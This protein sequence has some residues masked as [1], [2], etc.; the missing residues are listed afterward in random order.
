MPLIIVSVLLALSLV[1]NFLTCIRRDR[2]IHRI[3]EFIEALRKGIKEESFKI[4]V[5]FVELKESLLSNFDKVSR[6]ISLQEQSIGNSERAGMRLSRNIEKAVNSASQISI[7]TEANRKSA[8]DLFDSVTEGSAAVEE[9]QAALGSFRKQNDRQNQSI[10]ETADAISSMNQSIKGVSGIAA[11]RLDSVKTLIRVTS[12]SSEK[13]QENEDVIR[14][15]QKQVDDVLSLITVINDIASQT[16]L[17]SMNAAI[18]AAHAGE[19][20]KGFAV[21]AEEIR[22]L[23]EST[24]QNSHIISGTL[25]K[26]VEHINR[27]GMIS[28][29]SGKSFEQIEKGAETV[30]EAFTVIHRDT[31][32]LL[33]SAHKLSLNT[34][35]LQEIAAEST[36]SISEIEYGTTDI[37]KVLQDSKQ[38]A[39][40]LTEDMQK[41]SSESK[42]SNFNLTKVSDSYLKTSESFLDI[43]QAS[44]EYHGKQNQLENKLF[45]SNLMVAHVNWMGLSRAILDGSFDKNVESVMDE[46]HSR[47]GIWINSR[48]KEH[49]KDNK[50]FEKL[51]SRHTY[52]HEVLAEIVA[53]RNQNNM[54][55]AEKKFQELTEVSNEIVQILMTLGYSDFV[56]WNDNLSVHVREFDDQHKVLLRLISDLFNRMEEGSGNDILGETLL[57]LIDY[58]EFHFGTEEKNF[59]LYDYPHKAEHIQQHQQLVEKAKELYKGIERNEGVLSIEVLDFLQNWVVNHIN[60]TDKQYSDFFNN[61]AIK[62]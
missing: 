3:I 16:N 48:G 20:G 51:R 42:I 31:E 9:I 43:M 57:K 54:I 44:S 19:A 2:D 39:S 30:A 40:N 12:E 28:R 7:H 11:G 33:S 34:E 59:H 26:L 49:I 24:G 4:S 5:P 53:L 55:E 60:K 47:L 1:M 8:Y 23:A 13:I 22:S 52:L 25:N 46:K 10:K 38:I 6:M 58:T 35:R 17:L 21:V 18:E 62:S 37:N 32:S 14:N 50:K 36:A 29:E 27:A 45:F 41:L 56:S 15:V 61:K